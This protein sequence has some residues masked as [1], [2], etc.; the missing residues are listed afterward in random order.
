MNLRAGTLWSATAALLLLAL[1]G[2]TAGGAAHLW[3]SP[4]AGESIFAA[5]AGLAFG[6][7]AW[8][9]IRGPSRG[10][11]GG[12]GSTSGAT[13]KEGDDGNPCTTETCNGNKCGTSTSAPKGTACTG[14]TC[15]QGKCCK[16]CW[17]GTTCRGGL[18][19]TYCGKTG[20]GCAA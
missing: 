8:S 12:D 13:C 18:S 2:I 16:G 6:V 14:C 17:D 11:S 20:A 1:A 7:S 9:V 4:G 15:N 3:G 19:R 5:T 10:T